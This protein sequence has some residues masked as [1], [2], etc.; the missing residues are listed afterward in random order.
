[1][2]ANNLN[3]IFVYDSINSA[4]EAAT[5]ESLSGQEGAEG[6]MYDTDGKKDL[7]VFG[8]EI[9]RDSNR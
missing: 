2:Y 9:F 1:M 7:P 4:A 3:C 5:L 8:I 6:V